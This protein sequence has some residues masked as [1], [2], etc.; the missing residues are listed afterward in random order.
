M[1]DFSFPLQFPILEI[2]FTLHLPAR[3]HCKATEEDNMDGFSVGISD[4]IPLDQNELYS[5]MDADT[6]RPPPSPP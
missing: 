6:A 1:F 3:V 4:C 5:Q 2:S